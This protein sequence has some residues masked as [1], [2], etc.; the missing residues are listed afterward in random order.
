MSSTVSFA[1]AQARLQARFGERPDE[2]VWLRLH[3]NGELGSYLQAA[4]QSTLRKWV[5]GISPTHDSHDIELALRQ[6]FRSHVDEVANWLP[7]PWRAAVQWTRCLPDLPALQHLLGGGVPAAWMRRDPLLASFIDADAMLHLRTQH[8]ADCTRLAEQTAQDE[9]L[10]QGWLRHWH[11]LQPKTTFADA[12]FKQSMKH[13]QTLLHAQLSPQRDATTPMLR[14]A[15]AHRLST[16]FRRYSF[17]PASA[18]AYLA[19]TAFDLER[20]R[21]DLVQR[22]LFSTACETSL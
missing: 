7:Q 1:Y 8:A 19:L 10:L 16:A 15:L 22:A 5:L 12:R 11:E 14:E 9:T 13:L 20:L 4:R 6:K 2:H 3:G 17:Q 18:C 21:G